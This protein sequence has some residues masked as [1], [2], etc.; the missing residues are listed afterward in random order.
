MPCNLAW[1]DLDAQVDGGA[2]LS[3][4]EKVVKR[5]RVADRINELLEQFADVRKKM[6]DELS[7]AIIGQRT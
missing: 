1:D 3:R 4:Y 7:K 5:T 6:L 2:G